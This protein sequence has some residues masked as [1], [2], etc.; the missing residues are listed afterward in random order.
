MML[1]Q[2]K[3]MARP[4]GM[5]LPGIDTGSKKGPVKIMQVNNW[6]SSPIISKKSFRVV[7]SS[8]I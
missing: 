1:T 7:P 8:E 3:N 2:I 5:L 4:K 6:P